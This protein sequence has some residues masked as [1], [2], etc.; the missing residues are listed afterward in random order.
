MSRDI[1]LLCP[2]CGSGIHHHCYDAK[3]SALKKAA[4]QLL[5]YV[6]EYC[7]PAVVKAIEK[8]GRASGWH[9]AETELTESPFFGGEP[10]TYGMFGKEDGR[11]VKALINNLLSAAGLDPEEVRAEAWR[12]VERHD[13]E[14][15]KREERRAKMTADRLAAV[16]L[17]QSKAPLD[18]KI[19][20][21]DEILKD[22]AKYLVPTL[23]DKDGGGGYGHLYKW[24]RDR[25]EGGINDDVNRLRVEALRKIAIE[26][27]VYHVSLYS[28]NGECIHTHRHATLEDAID[29]VT[30]RPAKY[31]PTSKELLKRA[32]YARVGTNAQT[33]HRYM[34]DAKGA[35]MAEPEKTPAAAE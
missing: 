6:P 24:L 14:N 20:K 21:L 22:M 4:I 10:W 31:D 9:D 15:K 17:F 19:A 7:D 13:A 3:K 32:T 25:Y 23:D 28:P 27:G 11:T 16:K 2:E 34:R 1:H 29:F 26:E 5:Q 12:T 33:L 30:G 18:E 35:W 8:A